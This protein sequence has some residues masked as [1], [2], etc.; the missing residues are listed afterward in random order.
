MQIVENWS[1]ITGKVQET[2]PASDLAGFGKLRLNVT[3]V[4]P[5]GSFPELISNQNLTTYR[6]YIRQEDLAPVQVGSTV[7]VTVRLAPHQK[8]FARPGSLREL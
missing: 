8:L 3:D 7:E 1:L 6:L 2:Q 4:Q 5:V